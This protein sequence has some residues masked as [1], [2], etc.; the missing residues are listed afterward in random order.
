MTRRIK[1]GP[2]QITPQSDEW[3]QQFNWGGDGGASFTRLKLVPEECSVDIDGART[4]DSAL[5]TLHFS[6]VFRLV[7]LER[8]IDVAQDPVNEL[9]NA[10]AAD[11]VAFL[12]RMTFEE[13][14]EFTPQLSKLESYPT[15]LQRAGDS[16]I[17]VLSI[18]YRG[19]AG[20]SA[21]ESLQEQGFEQRKQLELATETERK[22]QMAQQ[23]L[24]ALQAAAAEH[25]AKMKG[26]AARAE[27]EAKMASLEA[28]REHTR[29]LQN[30]RLEYLR[31]LAS[32]LN[33]DLTAVMVAQAKESPD[34]HIKLD[35]GAESAV[36]ASAV[37][38]HTSQQ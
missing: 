5:L 30:I 24:H 11:T 7:D 8:M 16:G 20:T 10:L 3:I 28:E 1:R 38:V 26:E 31:T 15:V 37:H 35:L 17:E 9:T 23:E 27:L 33:V 6:F 18:S 2:C 21:I 36:G 12:S 13:F 32:E 25:E 34:T 14:R 4:S 22:K 29:Q 19:S